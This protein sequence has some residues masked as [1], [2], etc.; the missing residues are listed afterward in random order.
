MGKSLYPKNL[1]LLYLN[2]AKQQISIWYQKQ[3]I[4]LGL[5]IRKIRE[6]QGLSQEHFAADADIPYSSVSEIEAGKTNPAIRECESTRGGS[7]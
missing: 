3:L 6:K 4:K 5:P 2:V 1:L 7:E